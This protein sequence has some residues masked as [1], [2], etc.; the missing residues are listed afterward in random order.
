MISSLI[1]ITALLISIIALYYTIR[2]FSLK[3]GQRFRCSYSTTSSFECEDKYIKSLIVENLKD[4]AAIIFKIYIKLGLN[5]YL[6]IEDF[7]D[8]PLILKPFEVYYKEYDPILFYSLGSD[9]TKVDKLIENKKVKKKILL[10]TTN[11]K[12]SVKSSTKQWDPIIPFFKNH[13]T[14]LID[15]IRFKFR[16]KNYGRNVKFLIIVTQDSGEEYIISV[17]KDDYRFKRFSKFQ[18]TKESIETKVSLEKF[19]ELQKKNQKFEYKNIEI[20][21]FK[22]E[23]ERV[24]NEYPKEVI[25]VESYNFFQY[26]I[27]AKILTIIDNY[28]MYKT[29][30]QSRMKNKQRKNKKK[31]KITKE[32]DE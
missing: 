31:E 16:D 9:I 20:I 11:G 24:I 4:R 26:R 22:E 21:D 6:L 17:Y 19:L 3:A 32:N 5:N 28:K 30:R 2:A 1:S 12:Y 7:S 15:P 13:S 14:A 25:Q 18:L 23:V 10:T 27:V 8:A 29:N